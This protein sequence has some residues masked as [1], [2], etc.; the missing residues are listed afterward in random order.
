VAPSIGAPI[1]PDW[2][3]N[4]F[5]ET[6]GSANVVSKSCGV[7]IPKKVRGWSG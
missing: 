1:A 2:T 5:P 6:R 3:R 7:T 4:W